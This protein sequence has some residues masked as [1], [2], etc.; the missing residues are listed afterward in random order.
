MRGID[1]TVD[2][3][4]TDQQ[5]SLVRVSGYIDTTTS[6]ELEKKLNAILERRRYRIVVDLSGV[7]YVSSAG[8]G[9]FIGEIREI[10]EQHGDLKLAGMS[11]DV[12]EVFELLEF[13]NI[14]E[15]YADATTALQRFEDDFRDDD[16]QRAVGAG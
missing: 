1:V 16:R 12:Y 15:A 5:I 11:P 13:Q 8:W 9:I 6:H 10:R 4:G 14:L 3:V 2:E 7:D